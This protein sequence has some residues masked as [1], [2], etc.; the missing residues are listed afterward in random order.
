[1]ILRLVIKDSQ[2]NIVDVCEMQRYRKDGKR[3]LFNLEFILDKAY[4]CIGKGLFPII[5]FPEA[6]LPQYNE[7][8]E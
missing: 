5:E 1:M 4:E 8:G 7:K 3:D 6:Y 2:K